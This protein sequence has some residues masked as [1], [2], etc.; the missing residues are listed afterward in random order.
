M[1]AGPLNNN[2][3]TLICDSHKP[4]S[5]YLPTWPSLVSCGEFRGAAGIEL[6]GVAGTCDIPLRVCQASVSLMTTGC[7][8]LPQT[9]TD[10]RRLPQTATDHHKL[11]Q[12]TAGPRNV[13]ASPRSSPQMPNPLQMES[14]DTNW[15]KYQLRNA[16]FP[17]AN[18]ASR[19]ST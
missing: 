2:T 16:Y 18:I 19:R 8:R 12:L 11:S 5:Q 14:R 7:H 17:P 6:R 3:D 10:Y 15:W 13:T 9:A 1:H 4:Q